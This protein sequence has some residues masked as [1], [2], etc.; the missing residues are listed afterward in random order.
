M[1]LTEVAGRFDIPVGKNK[2]TDFG[3]G[4]IHKTYLIQNGDK[5]A[6]ILQNINTFVFRN[7]RQLMDNAIRITKH[8]KVKTEEEKLSWQLL[9][10]IPSKEGEY[11]FIDDESSFWR[12]FRFIPNYRPERFNHHLVAKA[13][14]AYGHFIRMMNDLPEPELYETIPDFHN[15]EFRLQEFKS[16][17]R[18]GLKS[19]IKEAKEEIQFV[20]K[21][22]GTMML[23]PSMLNDGKLKKRI[24]HN[25]TKF[26]NILFNRKLEVV[27]VIDLDT[28]MPGLVHSDF[29]DSIRSFGNEA[30]ED[31]PEKLKIKLNL[32][33]FESFARGFLGSLKTELTRNEKETLIYAPSMFAYMQGVRFLNDYLLNDPYYKIKYEKHNLIRAKNQFTLFSSIMEAEDRM[34]EI[35]DSILD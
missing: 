19:R 8:L 25:D 15:L 31:E 3:G 18:E 17:S 28:V 26:D 30:A 13:G 33:I 16:A 5:D 22:I 24:T 9:D 1:K 32:R 10:F 34:R 6:C 11:L 4:H 2:I 29:G 21:N 7:P 23:L 27:S 20:E 12:M 35:I 14:E